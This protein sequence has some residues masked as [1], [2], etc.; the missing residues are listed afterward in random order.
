MT[1][2]HQRVPL[3]DND[4][5]IIQSSHCCKAYLIHEWDYKSFIENKELKY[6]ARSDTAEFNLNLTIAK[7]HV[8]HGGVWDMLIVF[9]TRGRDKENIRYSVDLMP[10]LI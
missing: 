6:A 3:T 2:I 10:H 4:T 8:S 5:V 7:V 9:D 1:Y